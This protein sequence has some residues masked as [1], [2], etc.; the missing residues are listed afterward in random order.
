MKRFTIFLSLCMITSLLASS[1]TKGGNLAYSGIFDRRIY[2]QLEIMT[3]TVAHVNTPVG[4]EGEAPEI[5]LLR[6]KKLEQLNEK[7]ISILNLLLTSYEKKLALKEGWFERIVDDFR[8]NT[9]SALVDVGC[10]I[11]H[12][13]EGGTGEPGRETAGKAHAER[14]RI[15]DNQHID[16]ELLK[17]K[18]EI[19][20]RKEGIEFEPVFDLEKEYVV[21][22]KDIFPPR[23]QEQIERSLLLYRDCTGHLL[24]IERRFVNCALN[25]PRSPKAIIRADHRREDLVGIINKVRSEFM[26]FSPEIVR[27]MVNIAVEIANNSICNTNT[28]GG[29]LRTIQYFWGKP[30]GGKT[31][32]VLKL[33]HI[34]GLPCEQVSISCAHDLSSERLVGKDR[35]GDFRN[36]GWFLSPLLKPGTDGK[37]YSNAIL[38]IDDIDL[39]ISPDEVLSILKLYLD[40]LT[41]VFDSPYFD[42]AIGVERMNIF[43]TSNCPIPK[44]EKYAALRSRVPEV[45]FSP[46]QIV[47]NSSVLKGYVEEE[48]HKTGIAVPTE[49]DSKAVINTASAILTKRQQEPDLR[50]MRRMIENLIRDILIDSFEGSYSIAESAARSLA[51]EE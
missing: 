41:K 1:G 3:P 33:A 17:I 25:L 37:T 48:A 43:V 13:L 22:K 47:E 27:D 42:C 14:G 28:Y 50:N 5:K 34:L 18:A 49:Q 44:T 12:W 38:L 29:K 45:E 46:H 24:E 15:V 40:P 8:R 30:G 10:W 16:I 2:D 23:L 51:R 21:I 7:Y 19:D 32:S 36:I 39:E 4:T 20:Q 6:Q 35:F 11:S 9:S 31:T 26:T